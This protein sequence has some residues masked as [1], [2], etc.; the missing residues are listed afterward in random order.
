MFRAFTLPIG[1]R[2]VKSEKRAYM[3]VAIISLIFGLSHLANLSSGNPAMII[4]QTFT[5]FF[6]SIF[7]CALYLRSGSII[8]TMIL[9]GVYDWTCFVLDPTLENG[10]PVA[11]IDAG[12]IFSILFALSMGIVGLYLIRPSMQ[13]R[14]LKLWNEKWNV[15]D[16]GDGET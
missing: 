1:M 13:E 16:G 7:F 14:I 15:H 6:E 12:I 2:Y 3:V 8:P 11:E 10:I 4:V 5:T 9:H